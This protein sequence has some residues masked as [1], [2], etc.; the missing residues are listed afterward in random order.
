MRT[1]GQRV[2]T[3]AEVESE[4]MYVNDKMEE[5]TEDFA[6]LA[7]AAARADHAYKVKKAIQNLEASTM[8]GNGKDGRTTVD[9]REAMVI[10]ACA[11]EL[12]VHLIAEAKYASAKVILRTQESRMDSLRTLSAN[13]RAQT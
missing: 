10:K 3:Q 12:L 2:V 7:E 1:P 5:A 11:D 13:I 4:I 6:V 8:P 9:E